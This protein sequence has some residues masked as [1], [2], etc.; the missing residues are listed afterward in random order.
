MTAENEFARWLASG[1]LSETE[2]AELES[3]KGDAGELESRFGRDLEFGTAGLRGVMGMGTNRMNVYVVRHATQAFA[4][5]ILAAG[6]AD[7]GAAV[8][9]DCRH[10]SRAFAEAAAGVFA[11]NGIPCAFLR[12]CAP[13]RS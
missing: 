7:R 8:C 13:P 6:E 5:A 3:I 12:I 10:L 2:L 1:A 4:D 11:A 9:H